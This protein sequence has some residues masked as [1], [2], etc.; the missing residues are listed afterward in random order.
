MS[1]VASDDANSI[2]VSMDNA[3]E[4]AAYS[5]NAAAASVTGYTVWGDTYK[6]FNGTYLSHPTDS[7]TLSL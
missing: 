4:D 7:Q 2:S 1:G 5:S 3:D 6:Y